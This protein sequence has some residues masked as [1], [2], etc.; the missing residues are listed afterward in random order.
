MLYT[1]AMRLQVDEIRVPANF[2]VDI[3]EYDMHPK[4]IALR[5]Y[6][7]HWRHFNDS[8]RLKCI[9]YLTRVKQIIEA[10]GVNVTLEPIYDAYNDNKHSYFK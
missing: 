8:E 4:F 6:E 3:V 2:E 9:K 1:P 7:S 10:H 5:F